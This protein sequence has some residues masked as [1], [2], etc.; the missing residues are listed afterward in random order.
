MTSLNN[1][2]QARLRIA[3]L[4]GGIT[5]LSAAYTLAQAR[6]AGAPIDEF[7]IEGSERLGGVIR[8][9]HIE[10]FT[11]EAGPDSFLSE[12]PEAAAL[13]RAL[14]LGDSLLGSNDE[15]RRTYILHRGRLV[16][17]PEGLQLLV[18]TRYWPVLRTPLIPMRGKLAIVAEW[19]AGGR[20]KN[21]NSPLEDKGG[22]ES[23]ASFVRRHFDDGMVDNIADPLLAGIY[24]GDSAAL[25]VCS[26]L[27]RFVEMERK[28]GSLIRG[29]QV[30][31]K[32]QRRAQATA[33]RPKPL[34]LFMTIKGGLQELVDALVRNLAS[35]RLEL[36]KRTVAIEPPKNR[37]SGSFPSLGQTYSIR[38]EGGT[39]YEADAIILCLPAH[40]CWP[41]LEPWDR[42][43]AEALKA[44]PYTSALTVALGYDAGALERLPAGFGFLVPRKEGRRMLA[45]TFVHSKFSH[46]TPPGCAL[47]RCFFGG[48]RDGRVLDSSDEEIVALAR[49]ELRAVLNL[50][51]PPKF[52][53]V[54]RWPQAMPQY[55][56][57]HAERLKTI[58]SGLAN[59]PGLFIAGNAYSGIG[60]SD[61]IRAAKL[62]AEEAV[63]VASER[64]RS[65]LSQ[66]P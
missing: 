4:G 29:V 28:Y 39:T 9:E 65:N 50:T 1:P 51:A 18:P 45:C 36:R 40:A 38:C 66:L 33:A 2:S 16:P 15:T 20:R 56:I 46:R 8:T 63:R 61:C 62:A 12:K 5:G 11:I 17:L 55:V 64:P 14:G 30:A 47:L 19:F 43:L 35:S 10:G 26:V 57:G 23:V 48:S 34:P 49:E 42:A 52:H 59:H 13:C 37:G 44:I 53:R 54:Y 27:P 22:D 3:V 24:G 6:Q 21:S 60:L 7:L 31:M 32:E 58:H 41:L 25:S